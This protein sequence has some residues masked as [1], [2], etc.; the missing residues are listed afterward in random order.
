MYAL[1]LSASLIL[2]RNFCIKLY[3]KQNFLRIEARYPNFIPRIIYS[4]GLVLMHFALKYGT[5][6][7]KN[8]G[9]LIIFSPRYGNLRWAIT[10]RREQKG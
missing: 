2:R 10:G 8:P 6:M 3:I 4:R 1:S 9:P 7:I 5:W